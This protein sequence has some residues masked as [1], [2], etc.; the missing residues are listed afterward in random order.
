MSRPARILVLD[1]EDEWRLT[2]RMILE[3]AGFQVTTVAAR[4]EAEEVL[5]RSFFHVAL[6][7]VQ[8]DPDDRENR[9]GLDLLRS[10]QESR[11]LEAMTVL[12]TSRHFRS[13][14]VREAFLRDSVD[15]LDKM[16]IGN[17]TSLL[18]KIHEVLHERVLFNGELKVLWQSDAARGEAVSGLWVRE[19][20]VRRGTPE[21]E[22]V[23]EEL[24]DLLCRLFPTATSLM[25]EVMRPGL[26][27][28]GVLAVS[29]FTA[30]GVAEP[31]VVKFGDA[32]GIRREYEHY[33]SYVEGFVGGNRTTTARRK[34][35][36]QG[37]GGIIYSF[38]GVDGERLEDFGAFYRRSGA[39]TIGD[40]LRRLFNV[41]CMRWYGN[42]KLI[43][44]LDLGADYRELLGFTAQKLERALAEKLPSVQH[45][46]R[47]RFTSLS[48]DMTLRNPIPLVDS[49]FIRS[50]V[51]TTTHGD[52][53]EHNILL[54]RRGE[55]WLIDFLR[56]GPG[57][58]LRDVAQL[59]SVVRFQLLGAD[60]ATLDERFE[61]ER[62]LAETNRVAQVG[63]LTASFG[64]ANPALRKAFETSVALRSIAARFIEAGG[65]SDFGEYQIASMFFA[66]NTIR[67]YSLP[68]TQREH[69]LLAASLLSERLP[70]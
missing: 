66:A 14:Y 27:G 28:S 1:D 23:G 39:D 50:S 62:V 11:L 33:T 46:P 5:G 69:A 51:T 15:Y 56:T 49:R 43:E 29:S 41:T 22:S 24:E 7:D 47:L 59:D 36:T 31:V 44:P 26:S 9:E 61:M 63:E 48:K 70:A 65:L 30:T 32:Q 37:M 12:V 52:F 67:F 4:A 40:V 53:N 13:A 58:V 25:V 3:R 18:A 64:T 6:L 21:I 45:G 19:H 68:R 16:E 20:R 55:A 60:E 38:V 34:A 54:D 17:G 35:F 2:F 57:H 8:L 42:R 10:W